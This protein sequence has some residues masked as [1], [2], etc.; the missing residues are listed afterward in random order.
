MNRTVKGSFSSSGTLTPSMWD[1][2]AE[3]WTFRD[4][5]QG[6]KQRGRQD[7]VHDSRYSIAHL[8]RPS[9]SC[10]CIVEAISRAFIAQKA[11][12]ETEK[13]AVT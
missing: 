5:G 6:E 4:L 2:T 12:K 13:R 11:S 9:L 8:L 10:K 3:L 1:P 7:G